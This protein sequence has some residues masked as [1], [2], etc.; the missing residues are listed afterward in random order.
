MTV[1]LPM[2]LYAKFE[3]YEVK[4]NNVVLFVKAFYLL[5]RFFRGSRLSSSVMTM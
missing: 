4:L 2:H 3:D 1:T 5:L